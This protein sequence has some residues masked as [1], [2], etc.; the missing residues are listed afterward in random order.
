MTT[1]VGA[2]AAS[3][4]GPVAGT[5]PR[6][7]RRTRSGCRSTGGSTSRTVRDGWSAS[8]VPAPTT[9]AWDSARSRWA[10]ARA[11]TPVI[12]RDDPSAAAVRPSRLIAV[13]T[14]HHAR[15]VRRWCRYGASDRRALVAPGPT[16]TSSPA[17]RS[18]ASPRPATL[19]SGS[20]SATTTRRTPAAIE[21]V[22]A[23]RRTPVEGT[24]LERDVGGPAAGALPR[25]P[26][27]VRPR[28][29]GCPAVDATPRR[30]LHPARRRRRC[31]PRDLAAR[32]G[33]RARPAPPPGR[34]DRCPWPSPAHL[35]LRIS[36]ET[37]GAGTARRARH[38]RR[39]A[40]HPLP[41]GL[42]P[43]APA[44]H[45]VNHTAGG[46]GLAGFRRPCLRL[47]PVGTCTQTPRALL[48]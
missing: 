14:R 22:R 28:R 43:S 5:R 13:F 33:V 38:G 31:R 36:A 37:S 9:T 19:V 46:R 41:S 16:S 24:G 26:E 47:P 18:R 12:Q 11:A 34:S 48:I 23:G 6:A 17:A 39:A 7:S 21:R 35:D 1:S 40:E 10:S 27:G 30:R 2:S 29:G 25:R 44:S 32:T 4:S 20:S 3:K 8:A 42:S 45:R 15:P